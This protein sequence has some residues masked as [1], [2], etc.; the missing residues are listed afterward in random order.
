ME[1]LAGEGPCSSV[2][3]IEAWAR[4]AA[5]DVITIIST[6]QTTARRRAQPQL[7]IGDADD[8]GDMGSRFLY[9]MGMQYNWIRFV[10]EP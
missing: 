5:T 8:N 7:G 4:S 2:G 6:S 1:M 3:S 9:G 10:Y